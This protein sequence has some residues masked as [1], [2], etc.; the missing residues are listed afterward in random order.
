MRRDW[1]IAVLMVYC[2]AKAKFI[3]PRFRKSPCLK[4]IRQIV[5]EETTE[6]PSL[7]PEC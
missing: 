7:I 3:S 6:C 4:G 2:A 5:M 1:R